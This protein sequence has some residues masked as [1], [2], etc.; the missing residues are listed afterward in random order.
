MSTIQ[1][2]PYV[3]EWVLVF[4]KEG[5]E[6]YLTEK[7]YEFYKE[8]R[9]DTGIFFDEFS[10][11]PSGVMK[12]YRRLAEKIK[13]MYPCKP[14]NGNGYK[15]LSSTEIQICSVCHGTGIAS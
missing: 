6:V 10:F 9:N 14:C 2:L 15:S 4:F 8:H 1:D 3:F 5:E 13:E 7:Q 12:S 11:A